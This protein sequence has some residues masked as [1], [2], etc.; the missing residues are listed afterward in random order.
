MADCRITCI[1]K[2]DRFSNHEHITHAGNKN[3]A[4]WVWTR[5]AI[6]E[7]IESKTN[8]FYVLDGRGHRSEVGVVY[9]NDGRSPFI[10]THAD[11]YYNDNLLS[12]P[13]CD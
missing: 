3:T 8:T 9:P 13:E 10:R 1:T 5:E 12:L 4:N 11:G 7:S 2:P 6:I